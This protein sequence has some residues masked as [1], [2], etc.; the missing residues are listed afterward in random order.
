MKNLLII[1]CFL[2]T[3]GI[4]SQTIS[5]EFSLK[6]K[7][8]YL[9]KFKT[10]TTN[11]SDQK[12]EELLLLIGDSQSKFISK[13]RIIRDSIMRETIKNQTS[14]GSINLM[15]LD[16]PKTNIAETV[17][18]NREQNQIITTEK[19]GKDDYLYT[20][21]LKQLDWRILPETKVVA[22]YK[23]QKAKTYFAGR[24]YIAW[25]TEELPISEGPYKFSGLPGLIIQIQDAQN[26]YNY[27]L[28]KWE[29]INKDELVE[30]KDY[31]N[32]Y[33]VIEKEEFF[34][35]KKE[36]YE[37][38]FQRAEARGITLMLSPQ[39]KKRIKNKFKNQNNPIELE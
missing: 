21:E 12:H 13:A 30:N 32:N 15:G 5:K 39:D 38:F 1:T 11:L 9:L 27:Q 8:T 22:G 35:F 10:D 24:N 33:V 2:Y 19:K 34:K 20:E 28:I 3:L 7:A 4:S 16:L 29:N 36:Y 6:F 18:K 37:N 31:T 14:S 25:F 17:Y 26:H 23:V